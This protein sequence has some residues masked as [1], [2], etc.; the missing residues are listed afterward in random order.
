MSELLGQSIRFAIVGVAN[1]TVGLAAIYAV[2]FFYGVAPGVA[3]MLG[4]TIGLAVS[5]LLNRAWTFNNKGSTRQ[6]LPRYL[7]VAACSYCLNL[8]ALF[9]S[10][11]LLGINAYLGQ[12]FGV[13][14]YTGAMFFGCRLFVFSSKVQT[15]SNGFS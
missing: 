10:I 7:L 13:L 6:V 1:T 9:T 3:N 14:A 5:F 8:L 2:M 15:S 11:H 4:Y 12:I